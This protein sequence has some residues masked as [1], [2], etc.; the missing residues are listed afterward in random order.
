MQQCVTVLLAI[1]FP[2]RHWQEVDCNRLAAETSLFLGGGGGLGL[3][4]EKPCL[5][6]ELSK[7]ILVT[8]WL[9]FKMGWPTFIY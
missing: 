4:G 9:L 3:L 2:F 8:S 5:W 1:P 6:I 7:Q